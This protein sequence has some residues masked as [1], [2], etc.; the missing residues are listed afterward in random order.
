MLAVKTGLLVL[1][2]A[3]SAIGCVPSTPSTDPDPTALTNVQSTSASIASPT[4]PPTP[5]LQATVDAAVSLVVMEIS[6]GLPR[7]DRDDWRHWI[8]VDGDCQNTR[9]EVLIEES[10]RPVAFATA[11]GC[12][13]TGGRWLAPFTSTVVVDAG[14]LDVDHMVPLANAHDSGAWAWDSA[15]KRAYANYLGDADPLDS[16]NGLGE[17]LQGSSRP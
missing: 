16:C 11:S 14:S 8:D 3:A 13:V 10:T 7:Y 1:A 5:D 6:A 2:L 12:R 9:A 17:P 15:Q 4:P